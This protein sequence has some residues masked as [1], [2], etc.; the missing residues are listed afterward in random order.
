PCGFAFNGAAVPTFP[1]GCS[2]AHFQGLNMRISQQI[3]RS[4]DIQNPLLFLL[5]AF[6]ILTTYII[7]I[8]INF[9]TI[10]LF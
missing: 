5:V 7:Y 9:A 3:I 2:Q 4:L 1:S 8:Y 6:F 10:I